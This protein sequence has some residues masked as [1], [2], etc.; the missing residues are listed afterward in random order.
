MHPRGVPSGVNLAFPW[1]FGSRTGLLVTRGLH[2]PRA[3]KLRSWSWEICMYS[4]RAARPEV[5]RTHSKPLLISTAVTEIPGHNSG[6]S[7][8]QKNISQP[9]ISKG[10][11]TLPRSLELQGSRSPGLFADPAGA[12]STTSATHQYVSIAPNHTTSCSQHQSKA[13]AQTSPFSLLRRLA[14]AIDISSGHSITACF[15]L[16]S[17]RI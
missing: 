12:R 15:L 11:P 5:L 10:R 6:T 17:L 4:H 16:P 1:Y 7:G 13:R 9:N 8:N 14:S 3:T 2:R